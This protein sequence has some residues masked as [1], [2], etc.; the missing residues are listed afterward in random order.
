MS[1]TVEGIQLLGGIIESVS[2]S[3]I[4]TYNTEHFMIVYEDNDHENEIRN[5][6]DHHIYSGPDDPWH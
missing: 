5:F 3:P 2:L 6:L 4:L 1:E